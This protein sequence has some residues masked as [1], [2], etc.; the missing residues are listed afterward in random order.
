MVEQYVVQA[1]CVFSHF[2]DVHIVAAESNDHALQQWRSLNG[3]LGINVDTR[4]IEESI[5]VQRAGLTDEQTF[6]DIRLLNSAT[7]SNHNF[8]I[9]MEDIDCGNPKDKHFLTLE[10]AKRVLSKQDYNDLFATEQPPYP[11]P[12]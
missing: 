1:K 6:R 7:V 3:K 2:I 10:E 9:S 12:Y 4:Y 8:G 11:S 5:K